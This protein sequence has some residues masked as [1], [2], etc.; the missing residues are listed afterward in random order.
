MTLLLVEFHCH[1]H[2]ELGLMMLLGRVSSKGFLP[3]APRSSKNRDTASSTT[4]AVPP[5]DALFRHHGA[6]DCLKDLDVYWA[7]RHLKETQVLPDSDLLKAVHEYSSEFYGRAKD[8]GIFDFQSMDET[9]LIAIGVLLEEWAGKVGEES[10]GVF[11]EGKEADEGI[12]NEGKAVS[13]EFS[14]SEED[15]DSGG[16]SH[17]ERE[18]TNVTQ[19]DWPNHGDN[20]P[21]SATDD[22]LLIRQR[23]RRKIHRRV[24][25][26][27]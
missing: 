15:E 4:V 17:D 13:E 11:V 22:A 20:D 27:D 5:E 19:N 2:R 8:G 3:F 1:W 23:K 6:P 14:H 25:T 24:D 9:A 26:R 21:S 12:S 7:N 18:R 10:W 16:S